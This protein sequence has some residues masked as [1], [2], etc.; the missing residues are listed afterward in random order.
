MK[1]RDLIEFFVIVGGL[2]LPWFIIL[3]VIT[4]LSLWIECLCTKGL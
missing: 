3:M 2:C 1:V 4:A